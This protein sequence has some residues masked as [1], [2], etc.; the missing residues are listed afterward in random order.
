M[1]PAA[2]SMYRVYATK[3]VYAIE[4]VPQVNVMPAQVPPNP[5]KILSGINTCET[6]LARTDFC[7]RKEVPIGPFGCI[8][9]CVSYRR[10]L[11]TEEV[12]RQWF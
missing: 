12:R 6:E 5:H 3:G 2:R 1:L 8:Q 4:R 9:L 7:P 10:I 11:V